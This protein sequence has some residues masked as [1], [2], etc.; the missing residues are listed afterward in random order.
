MLAPLGAFRSC[1]APLWCGR[2]VIDLEWSMSILRRSKDLLRG[3]RLCRR[4][5]TKHS[6]PNPRTFNFQSCTPSFLIF[7]R[8]SWSK[9]SSSSH[10]CPSF[11][12]NLDFWHPSHAKCLF[13]K[14][15]Y[16][17]SWLDLEPTW[18]HLGPH[19]AP[20]STG[21]VDDVLWDGWMLFLMYRSLSKF[22]V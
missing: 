20:K 11:S 19:L 9:L 18:T 4:P 16:L 17:Q 8:T 7:C 3:V 14:L 12:C 2:Y 21:W 6:T 10:L 5:P 13:L 1:A 22:K 15:C